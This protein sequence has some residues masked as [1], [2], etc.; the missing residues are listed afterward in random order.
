MKINKKRGFTL[1]ELMAVIAII[2]ILATVLIPT[3]TGYINRSRKSVVI[4]QCKNI[5][6]IIELRE[7]DEQ[8]KFKENEKQIKDIFKEN[9]SFYN[10]DLITEKDVNKI[11]EVKLEDELQ[12][13]STESLEEV[14]KNIE[15]DIIGNFKKLNK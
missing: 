12:Y 4:N 10:Y 2:A 7:V 1:I 6:R 15:I 14:I 5:H 3:I 9:A 8:F 11:L 13:I